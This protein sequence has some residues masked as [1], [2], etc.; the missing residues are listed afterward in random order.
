MKTI[1]KFEKF[2]ESMTNDDTR[3]IAIRVVDKLVEEG[4]VKNS[5]DTDDE[6]EFIVQDIIHE[7]LNKQLGVKREDD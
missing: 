6:N 5:I 1:K 2:N 7:E 4:L 3:D